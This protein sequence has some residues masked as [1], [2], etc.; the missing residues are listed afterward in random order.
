MEKL[1]VVVDRIETSRERFASWS[2]LYVMADT[3]CFPDDEWWEPTS[4]VLTIWA[5]NMY[6]F[7]RGSTNSIKLPYMD[8]DYA[9]G[10]TKTAKGETIAAFFT[11]DKTAEKNSA[12]GM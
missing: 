5:D 8:G 10:L 12:C 9:I 6:K 3:I 2:I 1:R 11:A 7:L 4:S